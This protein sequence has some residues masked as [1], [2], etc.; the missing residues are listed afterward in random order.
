LY[1][2]YPN[3]FNPVTT[4]SFSLTAREKVQLEVF[5][6]LG[7]KVKTLI[8][9]EM[10]AGKHTVIWDARNDAGNPL[11]SGVYFYQISAGGF[12]QTRKMILL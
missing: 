12:V 8:S 9:R 2:S 11:G 4:I 1:Q 5:N 10:P 7:Q 3:P 6:S